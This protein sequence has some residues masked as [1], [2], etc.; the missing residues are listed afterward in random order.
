[1][2][3]SKVDVWDMQHSWKKL[4][5]NT[6]YDTKYLKRG[7]RFEGPWK[8]LVR[9]TEHCSKYLK[10]GDHFEDLGKKLVMFTVLLEI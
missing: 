9:H 4:I 3:S 10:R 2:E 7:D 8:K 5:S 1:M 6:E